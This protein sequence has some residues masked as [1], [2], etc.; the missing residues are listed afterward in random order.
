MHWRIGR[1]DDG[2]GSWRLGLGCRGSHLQGATPTKQR[3]AGKCHPARLAIRG[4]GFIRMGSPI[5]A[6]ASRQGSRRIRPNSERRA[7]ERGV[8]ILGN[9]IIV[10]PR[11]SSLVAFR[12]AELEAP[13]ARCHA[14]DVHECRTGRSPGGP[15]QYLDPREALCATESSL[16][17]PNTRD[18]TGAGP[19]TCER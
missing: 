2:F 14:L 5:D 19:R 1:A 11:V 10:P 8:K 17:V 3:D 13:L 4:G 7:M 12:C 16:V 9:C 15:M 18:P 6:L